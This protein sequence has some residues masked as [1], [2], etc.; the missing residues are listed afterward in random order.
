MFYEL[1]YE[2]KGYMYTAQLENGIV[3]HAFD[4]GTATGSDGNVYRVVT[5]LDEEEEVVTDGWELL[6]E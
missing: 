4:D 6:E 5:H 3:I 2:K 1:S